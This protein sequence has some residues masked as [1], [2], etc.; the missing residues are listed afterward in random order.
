MRM[1]GG[2]PPWEPSPGNV[3]QQ[4]ITA[5]NVEAMCL[6]RGHP[7]ELPWARPLFAPPADGAG[8]AVEVQASPGRK[9]TAQAMTGLPPRWSAG[10]PEG[11]G[12]PAR[13]FDLLL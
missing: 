13:V 12:D 5:I 8:P 9:P 1:L 7:R 2:L 10:R 6:G 11:G 4:Q 3:P